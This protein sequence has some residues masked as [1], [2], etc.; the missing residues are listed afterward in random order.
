MNRFGICGIITKGLIFVSSEMGKRVTEKVIKA[1]LAK[2][3]P[4]SAKDI[5]LQIQEAE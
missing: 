4:N 2:N 5:H 3:F 1:I